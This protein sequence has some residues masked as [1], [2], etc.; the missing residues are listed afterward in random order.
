METRRRSQAGAAEIAED[1]RFI[2]RAVTSAAIQR[3]ARPGEMIP[4]EEWQ[5]QLPPEAPARLRQ[6]ARDP[7]GRAYG[8]Q[9]ADR[10]PQ[11]PPET[12]RLLE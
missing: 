8:P 4:T 7:F 12:A 3:H 6:N 9:Q 1:L 10:A 11:P 5:R 2:E